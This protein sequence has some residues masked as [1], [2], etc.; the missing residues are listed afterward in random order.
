MTDPNIIF[1]NSF[2]V[3]NNFNAILYG[4]E[5]MLY[6]GGVWL[7]LNGHGRNKRSDTRFLFLS[8]GLLVMITIYVAVQA[9]FG[10]EMWIV[11]ANYPGGSGQYLAD[12]AAAWYETLGSAATVV[13]NL[14][15]DALLIY[16]TYVVWSDWR[17]VIFP[18]ILY[19]GTTALGILTCYVSGVPNSDFFLGKT[20]QIAL[21]Y[22]SI[23]I[24]LNFTC[25][26]LI[27]I[28]ILWVAK[29]IEQTLGREAS[30]IYTGAASL[31]IESMLPYTLF[32]IA[33]VVTLGLNHP[34]SIFFLSVYVMFTCLSPQM[35]I[36]RVLMGRGWTKESAAGTTARFASA[37][38]L[39]QTGIT[40]DSDCTA[41]NLRSL[42]KSDP[43]STDLRSPTETEQRVKL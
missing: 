38:N 5:L 31:I 21:S 43:S 40:Y 16:R 17:V 8:T 25:S 28:R 18:S 24:A 6:F 10:E 1:Q 30:K 19:F 3:G 20:A 14:M 13:L 12:N 41:I 32:G 42:A 33:Y 9:V 37:L 35:I 15:S 23:V 34:T 36:V 27:C 22:S 39:S 26:A 29:A 4:V 7:I 11:H 2:Y